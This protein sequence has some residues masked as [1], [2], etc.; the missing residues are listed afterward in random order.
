VP[1]PLVTV[2]DTP[3]LHNALAA[4]SALGVRNVAI[5]VGYKADVIK[6]SCGS[7][8]RD[9]AITY[10]ESPAFASTG[11]AHSLWLSRETLLAGDT[12]VIEGDVVFESEALRRLAL[13][14]T[15]RDAAAVAPF[16]TTMSGSAVELSPSGSLSR[17]VMNYRRTAAGQGARL[18][19]TLNL[20]AFKAATLRST[21]VPA[22]ET[23]VTQGGSG[24]YVEQ[25]LGDLI[26]SGR[27]SVAAVLC[28]DLKWFEIDTAEDL[29]RAEQIFRS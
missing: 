22:L 21:L 24:S 13:T 16:D 18:F 25:V 23:R 6:E 12:L 8:F 17:F 27:L 1:K 9:M 10:V 20:Y 3:I 15:A 7:V 11:S 5:V 14:G 4:L 26:A 19:K 28:G 2:R 29:R